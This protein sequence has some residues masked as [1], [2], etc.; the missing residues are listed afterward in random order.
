ME[1]A[2]P[3]SVSA[4]LAEVRRVGCSL[5]EPFHYFQA[6]GSTNDEARS[7]L[8]AGALSGAVFLAD[9]QTQ[10][11]GRRGRTWFAPP[12]S[13]LWFTVALRPRLAAS[14]LAAITLVVGVA[15]RRA[16]SQQLHIDFGLKWPNDIE[17]GGRKVAG[18]LVE[19]E[20]MPDGQVALAIGVGINTHVTF[21]GSDL[22]NAVSLH[23]LAAVPARE[24]LLVAILQELAV[25][26]TRYQREGI[27]CIVSELRAHDALLGQQLSVEGVEGVAAGFDELGR[28]LLKTPTGT[29]ALSSGTV[30]RATHRA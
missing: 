25:W 7:A 16:L 18:I 12:A 24:T 29:V 6:C 2:A 4:F 15:L 13:G 10:G 21:A 28:L 23:E 11:R 8:R 19:A 27:G 1:P 20:S 3:F 14:E 9:A 30:E 26:F 17:F 22:P 5:G